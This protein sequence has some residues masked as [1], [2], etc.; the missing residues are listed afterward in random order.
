MP[1][2]GETW[3]QF[4]L[5]RPLGK[6]G[7]G[8]VFLAEDASLG[9]KVALKFL[10]ESLQS[11]PTARERFLQ[12]ARSAAALDHPYICKIYEIGEVEGK[13]YIAME[14]LEGTT[15]QEQLS[16]GALPLREL[17][18][19]GAEIAEAVEAAHKKQIVHRDLKT[20]NI[21]LT[22]DG[23]I[24]VMDF[25]LAKQ[26]SQEDTSE[27][28]VDT[29]SGRLTGPGATPGTVIYMS[30]EQVRGEP[31]DTRSDIFSVGV[32]LY[33][34]ATG[35]L[36]FHGATSGLTYDAILNRGPTPPRHLKPDLPVEMEQIIFKAL[37]KDREDR[38]QSAKELLVDLRRLKRDT[39]SGGDR[40]PVVAEQPQA[41]KKGVWATT[42][43]AALVLLLLGLVFFWPFSDRG[44]EAI[45]SLAVLPF[46]NTRNDPQVD[47]LSDGIAESLINRLSQ[48]PQLQVMARS[49]SFR[50]RGAEVDPQEAGRE[51]G[52]G[53]VLTGRVV[54]QGD[55]LNVQAELVDV[56]SGGQLWG[57]QY[58]H[59]LADI[60][61]VQNDIATQISQALRLQLTGQ[62]QAQ[63]VQQETANSD[64]YHAYLK[65]RYVWNKRT[66]RDFKK[67]IEFFE[68]AGEKDPEYALAQAGLADCYIL[69]GSQFYG[70]DEDF[71]PK[72]S[73][74]KA[75]NAAREALR[76]DPSL[77]EARASLAFIRFLDDWDWEGAERDF[78]QAIALNP[79]YATAHQWYSLLLSSTGRHDEAIEE[80]KHSLELEPNSPVQNRELGLAFF[81]ARR[82]RE[83]VEQLEKTLELDSSFPLAREQLIDSY[84]LQ[85]MR[86]EAMAEAEKLDTRIGKFYQ[87]VHE[88][89]QKEA[90]DLLPSLPDI[91]RLMSVSRYYVLAGDKE[92]LLDRLEGAV[93]DRHPQLVVALASPL[94][95]P[96][97]SDPRFAD[98]LR[99]MN[100]PE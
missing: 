22:S 87:L 52:V 49:T 19:A 81:W 35:K 74:A 13:A 30:P 58:S 62:E 85:G 88:G 78:R 73:F 43:A 80:A 7:M 53:A 69:L 48:L 17:L 31:V 10:S 66:N 1:S 56:E 75:R 91:N 98:L 4:K 41:R 2:S 38:Y 63:L 12:E 3:N 67:A 64:A 14:Y 93:L 83:A 21:K 44:G 70:V 59:E 33:E 11:E 76:L 25:G 24:K 90:A 61:E 20:P 51:L 100:F 65:G 47:Y 72:E 86:D 29:L 15:L 37:E 92:T 28:K 6:G 46:E 71:P 84:W 27:S 36:P 95:D 60:V 96:L 57:E 97:R 82:Y 55:S 32:V 77:A 68:D 34:M 9:R 18:Q 39:D 26:L 54:Q 89:K 23:H 45:D 5:V 16:S 79:S 99:R 94:L 8:E 42:A 40:A 50:Y